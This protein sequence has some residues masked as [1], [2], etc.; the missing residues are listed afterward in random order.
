M[1]KNLIALAVS[2]AIVAPAAMAGDVT[3]YG[4]AQVEVASFSMDDNNPG[5][6]GKGDGVAVLD[7]AMG[8][9]G[10]KASED[11]G[12]GMK[13]ITVL[14]Y[15]IDTADGDSNDKSGISLTK[16]ETMVGL[17]GDNWG[18]V[19]LGRLKSEY[20][21]TGGVKYDPFVAT[22]LEARNNGGMTGGEWGHSSFNSNMIGYRSPN[23]SGFSFGLTYGPE[24]DDSSFTAAAKYNHKMFEVFVSAVGTGDLYKKS[25]I[26]A[27]ADEY[28][29]NA[30]KFGG[31]VKLA[32][33]NHK[34]SLQYEQG[35]DKETPVGGTADE[36][37]N[38]VLFVGYQGKFGNSTFVAQFGQYEYTGEL[39]KD[40]NGKE[41]DTATYMAIGAI[42]KFSKTTRVFGGYRVTD[43]QEIVAGE[44]KDDGGENVVSIGLRKDF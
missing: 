30:V 40:V 16:R 33:G 13:G 14:E 21:Y 10:V 44:W 6:D 22:T 17:K 41:M 19:E 9:I 31:Q 3:V 39:S 43:N 34:I 7:N 27:G 1:K 24:N 36:G 32:G 4:R 28:E 37:D 26:S 20:K 15:K 42:Y 2:T 23:W 18:Q 12:G 11:L 8:R 29:Y 38:N 5:K 35:T 25:N